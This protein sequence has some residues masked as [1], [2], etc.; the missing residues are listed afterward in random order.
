M[1]SLITS[2][3]RE[4]MKKEQGP[5][6]KEGFFLRLADK[7]SF[8]MGTPQNIFAWIVAVLIWFFLGI[9]DAKIFLTGSFLPVWFTS[10][11]WNFPLNTI[12]TLAELYIGFLVAAAANRSERV[13]KDI[14]DTIKNTVVHVKDLAEAQRAILDNQQEMLKKMVALEE[15]VL[16]Q[17]TKVSPKKK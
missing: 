14:I 1:P 4:K 13:L 3:D 7:V 17:Q 5:Q 11:G 6:G 8:G 10:T 2:S 16:K 15:K 12:T 9:F